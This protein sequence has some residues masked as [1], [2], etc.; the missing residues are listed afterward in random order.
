MNQ[1]EASLDKL[2]DARETE[3]LT[4]SIHHI[5][6]ADRNTSGKTYNYN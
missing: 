3:T 2:N 5:K 4:K 6:L 1:G